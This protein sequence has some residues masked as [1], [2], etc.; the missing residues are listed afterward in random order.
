M[1]FVRTRVFKS[2]T[3]KRVSQQIALGRKYKRILECVLKPNKILNSEYL[4]NLCTIGLSPGI[5]P[6]ISAKY[7]DRL[8][9]SR[10]ILLTYS[11]NSVAVQSLSLGIPGSVVPAFPETRCFPRSLFIFLCG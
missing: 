4:K 10:G 7:L 6:C 1:T 8:L 3:L 2:T 5:I 11:V 9:F